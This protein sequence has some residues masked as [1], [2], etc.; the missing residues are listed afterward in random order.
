MKTHESYEDYFHGYYNNDR[1]FEDA[2]SCDDDKF[3]TRT[4]EVSEELMSIR[5]VNLKKILKLSSKDAIM[6][7][8]NELKESESG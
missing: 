2:C 3:M 1:V 6:A 4:D 8:Q 7:R 5:L